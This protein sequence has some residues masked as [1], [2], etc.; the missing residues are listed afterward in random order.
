M[1]YSKTRLA[2]EL[3]YEGHALQIQQKR[4]TAR[5]AYDVDQLYKRLRRVPAKATLRR[6]QALRDEGYRPA[7][8]EAMV[9]DLAAEKGLQPPD[10]A[11]YGRSTSTGFISA[12][13]AELVAELHQRET[14]E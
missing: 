2:H 4:C 3:G 9:A 8:I 13:A 12:V 1:G 5:N 6:L 7:R 10:L 14:E 11:I